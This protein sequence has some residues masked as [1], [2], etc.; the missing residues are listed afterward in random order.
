MPQVSRRKLDKEVKQ[1]IYESFYKALGL[2]GEKDAKY[3]VNDLLT[4]T[5]KI[6]IAKRFAIAILLS[7]EWSYDAIR[8]TLKVTQ[9]TIS[10]VSRVLTFSTGLKLAIVKLAKS[11]AWRAWWQDV[12]SLLYRLSS[13]SKTFLDNDL[14]RHQLRHKKKTLV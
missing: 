8:E 12:E 5:E 6:M 14:V 13:P 9:T 11:E 2:L 10:S 7:Q 1:K 3:F 4:P